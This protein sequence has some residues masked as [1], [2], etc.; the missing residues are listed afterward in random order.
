[1]CQGLSLQLLHSQFV[2]AAHRVHD[3]MTLSC[4]QGTR[5]E[6]RAEGKDAAEA[7]TALAVLFDNKFDEE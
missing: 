5:I 3:I 6:L 4:P 2:T 1:M 7:L